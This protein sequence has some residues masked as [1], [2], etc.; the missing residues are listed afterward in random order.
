[1]IRFPNSKVVI[2]ST[3]WSFIHICIFKPSS[4]NTA[5]DLSRFDLSNLLISNY[6]NFQKI[7]KLKAIELI[8]RIVHFHQ[9]FCSGQLIG[10][11]ML[12]I[13]KWRGFNTSGYGFGQDGGDWPSRFG[14][15]GKYISSLIVEGLG[16]W[17]M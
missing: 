5:Y 8:M 13:D 3:G 11:D 15:R 10:V 9:L 1:M 17:G 14:F 7:L 4:I 6:C 12:Y 16:S 2:Q